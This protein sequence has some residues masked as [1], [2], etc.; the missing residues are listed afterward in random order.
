MRL[1]FRVFHAGATV[2][3]FFLTAAA[4]GDAKMSSP[5]LVELFTSEGCSSCP[6]ADAA[7][8]RLDKEQTVAGVPVIVLSEHVDYWD[9]PGWKDPF[10]SS[11]FSARQQAYGARFRLESVYTPQMVVDGR[12]QFVGSNA[13]ALRNA[14]TKAASQNKAELRIV[15]AARNGSEVE[16][17][18]EAGHGAT[19]PKGN[20]NVWV[21]LARDRE[22]VSIKGGENSGRNLEHVAVVRVLVNGGTM[23]GGGGF[24]RTVRVPLN[25]ALKGMR[26]VVFLQPSD[27]G[28]IAAAAVRPLED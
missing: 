14:L 27:A 28:P 20:L 19:G 23:K 1:G 18:I 4:F 24:H 2:A 25:P 9:G 26:A 6:P 10:S 11:Q 22:S 17:E 8:A 12:E 16:V 15:K 7:L 5:V 3:L 13:P 21:A